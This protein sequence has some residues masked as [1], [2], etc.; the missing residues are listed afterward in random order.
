[1]QQW[2]LLMTSIE[3]LLELM[4]AHWRDAIHRLWLVLVVGICYLREGVFTFGG[5]LVILKLLELDLEGRVRSIM[6]VK[7]SVIRNE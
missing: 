2:L 1:M 5:E 6:F 3:T 7:D 4:L